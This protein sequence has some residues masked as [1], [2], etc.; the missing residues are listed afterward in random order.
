MVLATLELLSEADN[1]GVVQEILGDVHV[2][3]H[4]RQSGPDVLAV[5]SLDLV[6]ELPRPH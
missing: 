3:L 6:G 2:Q 5:A 4:I 1:C